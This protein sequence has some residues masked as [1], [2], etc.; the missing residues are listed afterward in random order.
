MMRGI[1][2]GLVT[3]TV[4]SGV[5]VVG[6]AQFAPETQLSAPAPEFGDVAVP[7][8]SEFNAELPDTAPVLPATE[9]RPGATVAP[10]VSQP[11]QADAPTLDT[12]PA[13]TPETGAPEGELASPETGAAP[14]VSGGAEDGVETLPGSSQPTQP[15][16]DDAPDQAEPL[17]E[18]AVAGEA[19]GTLPAPVAG[20]TPV[21][22]S[23]ADT[24]IAA[25]VPATPPNQPAFDTAPASDAPAAMPSAGEDAAEIGVPALQPDLPPVRMPDA[26]QGLGLAQ[27]EIGGM[28]PGADTDALPRIGADPEAPDEVADEPAL[29][30]YAVPFEAEGENPLLALVLVDGPG[31][32]DPAGFSAFPVPLTVAVDPTIGDAGARM[33]AWRAVGVEVV[34]LTPLPEGASPADVEV[35]FQ[36]FLSTVPQAV[37]VMDLPDALLQESRPRAAQVAEILAETGHGMITYERGL[38]SGLQVAEGKGVPAVTVFRVFDDGARDMTAVKRFLDQGAFRA[39]QAGN[40]VMVGALRDETALAITEWA[41][42]IRAATVSL[43]PVSA[44]LLAK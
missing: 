30:R 20:E 27:P 12:S 9:G 37:A 32:P 22:D 19:E 25:V 7:A 35:A 26:P 17:G 44:V 40:V 1:L 11:G 38:N 39:G 28:S 29:T 43:A 21:M 18:P 31:G 33:A 5:I 16:V 42:G 2:S 4:V 15:G 3:G 10:G 41:L 34:V 8:G 14:A 36:S 23:E 24:E 13:G 6:V